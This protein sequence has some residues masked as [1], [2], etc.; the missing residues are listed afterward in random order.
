MWV[1][2][3]L[4]HDSYTAISKNVLGQNGERQFQRKLHD[5]KELRFPCSLCKDNEFFAWRKTDLEIQC[6]IVFSQTPK[7]NKASA[8]TEDQDILP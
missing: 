3:V 4:V 5:Q 6:C 8:E 2:K 7:K 1:E